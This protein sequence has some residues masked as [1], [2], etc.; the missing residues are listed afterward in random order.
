MKEYKYILLFIVVVTMIG[1]ISVVTDLI[2]N[3]NRVVIATSAEDYRVKHLK[4][5]LD[6]KFKDLDIEILQLSTGKNAAKIKA[7]GKNTDIDIIMDLETGHAQTL[8]EN[9]EDINFIDKNIYLD[10]VKSIK[11]VPDVKY[12][13]GFIINRDVIEERGLEVPKNYEDL[14][15]P[16]YKGLI[17]M[18]DPKV[19]LTGYMFYLNIINIY[20]EEKGLE[21]IDNLEKNVKQ[22]TASGSLPVKMLTQEEIAIGLGMVSQAVKEKNKGAK[23]EIIIPETGAPNNTTS[24]A[25]IKGKIKNEN[26]KRVFKYIAE[27]FAPNIDASLYMP[28]RLYKNQKVRLENYP[29]NIKYGN[30]KDI[31]SIERKEDLISKWKY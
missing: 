9:F 3:K 24:N 28:D 26:V 4:E 31:D 22:F 6:K 12:A 2:D 23:L 27:D 30:M 11:Y 21:Y 7:E 16:E 8:K 25:V 5:E 29:Q 10:R 14:L 13:G 18:P 20:G 19:S 1:I 15:K 17:A